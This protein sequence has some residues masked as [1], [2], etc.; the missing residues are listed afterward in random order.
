MIVGVVG[1]RD[2]P[3]PSFV[4]AVLDFY[5]PIITN[6][7]SG[8]AR[9]VDQTAQW[10]ALQNG[11]PDPIIHRPVWRDASGKYNP[12]AGHERNALIIRDSDLVLAFQHKGSGGTQNSIDK[13]RAAGK[14]LLIWKTV[15][16][17]ELSVN[18]PAC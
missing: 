3:C 17:Q 13:S 8:G 18:G 5:K 16:E 1:S 4:K 9:G 12:K 11:Y 2:W 15:G 10:W 6:V 14:P 7:V